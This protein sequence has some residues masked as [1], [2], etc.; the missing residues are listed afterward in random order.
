MIPLRVFV[1]PRLNLFSQEELKIL[2]GPV[3]SPFTLA[4]VG[5]SI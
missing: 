5:G 4:S 2:D 3:A 1:I